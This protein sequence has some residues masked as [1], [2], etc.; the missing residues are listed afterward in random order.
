MSEDQF[1]G[2][3]KE[4]F[5]KLFFRPKEIHLPGGFS[6]SFLDD[7]MV[8]NVVFYPRK[9]EIPGNLQD[10]IKILR[11]ELDEEITIGGICFVQ[12]PELP[13]IL[14]FHGN[15]EIALDYLHFSGLFFK[16]GV[17]LAVV[18]FRGYGWSSGTPFYTCLIKD[19]LPTYLRF[20]GWMQEEGFRDSTFVMGRSLGSTCASEIGARDPDDLKGIF[21][22]SGFASLYNMMIRLF[23]I[24]GQK[25][26]PENLKPWSNDTRIA[27]IK[28]PV[29]IIHGSNDWIVPISEGELIH[30]TLPEKTEARMI[31]IRGAGHNDILM[32]ENKYLPPLKEFIKKWQ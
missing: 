16:C 27:K 19:A 1:V 22:E 21:F 30:E 31:A 3:L 7:P 20:R 32:H 13:T 25:I 26:T 9:V 8:S 14:M 29:L 5:F 6:T 17:N 10:N 28:K 11:L 24:K 18:D 4:F 15:G 2:W 12:D 23:R